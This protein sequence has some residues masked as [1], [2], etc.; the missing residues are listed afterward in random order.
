MLVKARDSYLQVSQGTVLI[1]CLFPCKIGVPILQDHDVS[2]GC[3]GHLLAAWTDSGLLWGDLQ[4]TGREGKRVFEWIENGVINGVSGRFDIRNFV[5][6]DAD[7]REISEAEALE[8][9]ADDEQLTIVVR[10]STLLEISICAVPADRN[11]RVRACSE[12]AVI[13]E[14]ITSG[15]ARL[16]R[17]LT[18]DQNPL[19]RLPDRGFVQYRPLE[20]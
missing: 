17:I 7:G 14:M 2:R 11:A 20:L 19:L 8:R 1:H 18:R 3:L 15:E 6:V 13:R 16:Q 9:G 10:R 5:I 12:R 4:F